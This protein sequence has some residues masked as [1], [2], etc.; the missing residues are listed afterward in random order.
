VKAHAKVDV[1]VYFYWTWALAG[2]EWSALRPGRFT[3]RERAPGTHEI[4]T[5]GSFS[6]GKCEYVGDSGCFPFNV[7][8][9]KRNTSVIYRHHVAA[10]CCTV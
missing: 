4:M 7:D 1:H 6:K 2:G 8:N 5:E 9:N 3:P 10:F